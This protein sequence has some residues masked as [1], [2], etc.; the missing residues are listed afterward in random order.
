MKSNNQDSDEK[1]MKHTEDLKSMPA[2]I[3]DHITTLE[4]YTTQKD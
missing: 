2:E 3:T 4:C 1:T